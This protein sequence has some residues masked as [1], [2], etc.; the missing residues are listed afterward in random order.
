M[1]RRSGGIRQDCPHCGTHFERGLDA[2]FAEFQIHREPQLRHFLR[3]LPLG[4]TEYATLVALQ[5]PRCAEYTLEVHVGTLPADAPWGLPGGGPVYLAHPVGA[6]RPVLPH[7]PSEI[8]ADYADATRVAELSLKAGS[9]LARRCLQTTL[10]AVYKKMPRHLDPFEE[11][12]WVVEND[13]S[14]PEE[15]AGALHALRKAGNFA[16]HPVED[17][18]TPIFELDYVHLE[19][20][21][22]VLDWFFEEKFDKPATRAEKFAALRAAVFP[23][24]GDSRKEPR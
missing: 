3:P 1:A 13:T 4:D 17:G 21:F 10:R 2:G 7:V 11:I 15:L 19:A 8:A 12:K 16:A 5:C 6:E 9:T 22:H 24:K 20:C 18:L 14:L 23:E